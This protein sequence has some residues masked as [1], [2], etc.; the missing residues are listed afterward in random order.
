MGGGEIYGDLLTAR[1]RQQKARDED[2]LEAVSNIR[3]SRTA[4]KTYFDAHRRQRPGNQALQVADIALLH[5]TQLAEQWSNRLANRLN[6]PDRI[7]A[8]SSVGYV[9]LEA[10]DRTPLQGTGSPDGVKSFFER[11]KE[12][13]QMER[14]VAA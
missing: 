3:D 5:N 8:I 1:A 4:N 10:L 6:G 12:L 2:L 9:S 13:E 7:L 11:W 14:E